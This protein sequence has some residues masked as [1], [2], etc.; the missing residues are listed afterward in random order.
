MK[1]PFFS[2]VIPVY[3]RYIELKKSLHSVFEQTETDFEL[4]VVDDGSTDETC[5]WLETLHEYKLRVLKNKNTKGACGARNTGIEEA[6]GKWIAFLD[7]DDWWRNDKL[8]KMR[9]AIDSNADFSVFYSACFYVDAAGFENPMPTAGVSGDISSYLGRMNPV[10]GFSSLVVKKSALIRVG[11]FDESL[12]A[13]QDIDLYFRLAKL[14]H[15]YYIPE[16]LAYI[17]FFSTNK[18]SSNYNNR[19]IGWIMVYEKHKK[20]LR[21]KDK[22]YHQKRIVRFAW[23]ARNSR[24]FFRF[25]PG[26]ILSYVFNISSKHA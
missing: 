11:G 10:R 21:F 18:I 26:A 8:A 13:R 16:R 12:P 25:L 24:H 7:S 14:D 20:S 22:L 23:D 3:N 17:S 15:F 19:L 4:L 1:S 6:K 5:A 2:V 9:A